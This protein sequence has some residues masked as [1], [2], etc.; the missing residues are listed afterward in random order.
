M[1][2]N[3]VEICVQRGKPEALHHAGLSV[4][5]VNFKIILTLYCNVF[6][7]NVVAISQTVAET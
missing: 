4:A 2:S 5:A 1:T 3:T 7:S 6:I